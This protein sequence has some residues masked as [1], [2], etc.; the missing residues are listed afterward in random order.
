MKKHRTRPHRHPITWLGALVVLALP[1]PSSATS[2]GPLAPTRV[3]AD[4]CEESTVQLDI[5]V[6]TGD[7]YYIDPDTGVPQLL[8]NN[9]LDV[10]FGD[11]GHVLVL[12]HY[13]NYEWNVS[14]TPDSDPTV[15][16]GTDDGWLRFAIDDDYDQY[17]VTSSQDFSASAMASMTPVVP[18][19]VITVD[20]D[21][22]PET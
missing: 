15:T 4:P 19:I 10:H 5:D 16:Y 3:T 22:P 1:V 8:S 17:L 13:T 6:A 14:V 11:L 21:C 9:Q 12:L 20:T 7:V 18:D 2:P